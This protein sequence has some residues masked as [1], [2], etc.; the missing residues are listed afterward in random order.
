MLNITYGERD[1][2][3]TE[4]VGDGELMRLYLRRAA[5]IFDELD[6]SEEKRRDVVWTHMNCAKTG[7]QDPPL[8]SDLSVNARAL[9]YIPKS[10][11]AKCKFL[12]D[13]IER[14]LE[15]MVRQ[16]QEDT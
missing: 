2:A 1:I 7:T 9:Q 15:Y 14:R 4:W 11:E 5:A 12:N 13:A 16:E 6:Y 8:L 3:S 10:Y